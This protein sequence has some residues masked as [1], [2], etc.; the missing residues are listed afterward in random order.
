MTALFEQT[1]SA[2]DAASTEIPFFDLQLHIDGAIGLQPVL[3]PCNR[4]SSKLI[5]LSESGGYVGN[6]RAG[7]GVMKAS[8]RAAMMRI[9]ILLLIVCAAAFAWEA[10]RNADMQP[11]T[12]RVIG[13]VYKGYT[14]G[15]QVQQQS[16]QLETRIGVLDLVGGLGSLSTGAE[17]P[18]LADPQ[19]PYVSLINTLNGRYGITLTFVA[20][21]LL[22][23]VAMLVAVIRRRG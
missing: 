11:V 9:C 22:F 21:M 7:G 8:M 2:L 4:H 1:K 19:K 13:K 20:L 14:I 10:S 17:V 18:L 12:G 3:E 5:V 15:Y 16:Y 23:V 6:V